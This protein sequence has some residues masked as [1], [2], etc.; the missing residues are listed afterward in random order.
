[1][2][3]LKLGAIKRIWDKKNDKK[4][5]ISHYNNVTVLSLKRKSVRT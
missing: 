2:K 3:L 1:M 5:L 4:A